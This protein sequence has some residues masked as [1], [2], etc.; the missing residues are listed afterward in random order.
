MRFLIHR[1]VQ[2]NAPDALAWV[3]EFLA[4]FDTS[5]VGWLR[6]DFGREYRDRLGRRYRKYR[7]VYGRCWYPSAR[8]PTIRM[9]CQVPGPFPCG[10]VTRKS[11]IYRNADGTWPPTVKQA[12]GPVVVDKRTG[13]RWKRVY[14]TTE[15]ANLAEGIVWIF[16]HEAFHWLRK[17]R[18]IPGR[19]NEVAADAYAD[20]RLEEFRSWV[21]AKG[22]PQP[23]ALESSLQPATAMPLLSPA[24]L[25]Q[26]KLFELA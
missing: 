2:A 10:I 14:G 22:K 8:Q 25:V 6:I 9:S 21:G 15:V 12:H 13:R 4:R 5:I 11:P 7:G 3:R 18:Q 20:A 1:D 24:Q 19:N 16:A 23:P 26:S 17:T